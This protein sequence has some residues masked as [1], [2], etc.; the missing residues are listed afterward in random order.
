[1]LAAA[2][3]A[4]AETMYVTDRL[5]TALRATFADD[6][7]LIKTLEVGTPL[8]VIERVDKFVHVR[9]PQ[10]TDGWIDARY[11]ANAVPARLQLERA[12]SDLAKA[13]KELTEAQAR[14]KQLEATA[15]TPAAAEIPA[16]VQKTPEATSPIEPPTI[17]ADSGF[18]WGW[19]V[20][21]LLCS[22]LGFGAGVT[23]V[24]ERHRKKLGGMYL[25][26]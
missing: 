1:L 23:W 10:G 26:I 15:Q 14:I 13:R 21:V 25:R 3:P 7:P 20:L 22:G 8:E 16:P 18:S 9:D 4:R 17:E 24:R 11:L 6:S 12:Q 2:L 5:A 19:F